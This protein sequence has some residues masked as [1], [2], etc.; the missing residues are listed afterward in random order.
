MTA[1]TASK[2]ELSLA[3]GKQSDISKMMLRASNTNI[4]SVFL[5]LWRISALHI[6]LCASWRGA[7]LKLVDHDDDD[8]VTLSSL[9]QKTLVAEISRRYLPFEMHFLWLRTKCYFGVKWGLF[10]R[11]ETNIDCV[12]WSTHTVHMRLFDSKTFMACRHSDTHV[13]LVSQLLGLFVRG[14]VYFC[15][16]KSR[17]KHCYT[18]HSS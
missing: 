9:F 18:L 11:W 15:Y 16:D 7:I 12:S 8:L 1:V 6:S 17:K 2:F 13:M 3:L 4:S 5:V 10:Y 14:D